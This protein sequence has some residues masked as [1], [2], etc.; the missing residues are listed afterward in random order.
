MK[1]GTCAFWQ[2][3]GVGRGRKA[4]LLF[5]LIVQIIYLGAE[6]VSSSCVLSVLSFGTDF[7][8]QKAGSHSGEVPRI[9]KWGVSDSL[10]LGVVC[11]LIDNVPLSVGLNLSVS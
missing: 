1:F 2:G 8:T 5:F 7:Y 3:V 6:N 4:P 9:Q 11:H 10:L